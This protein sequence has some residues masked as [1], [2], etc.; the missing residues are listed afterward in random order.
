VQIFIE[1]HL[2]APLWAERS[3]IDGEPY[4]RMDIPD[5]LSEG[6]LRS[7]ARGVAFR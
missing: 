6:V 3:L 5:E 2:L 4:Y 7:D 1:P